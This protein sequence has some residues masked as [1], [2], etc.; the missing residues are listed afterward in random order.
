MRI[1]GNFCLTEINNE[2]IESTR[3]IV[4]VMNTVVAA[5]TS[6]EQRLNRGP[7]SHSQ[8]Q[9]FLP[10]GGGGSLPDCLKTA[11]TTFFSFL[12]L[13]NL[14]KVLQRV[15]NGYFKDNYYFP[16]F[17]RGVQHFLGG[18]GG[19]QGAYADPVGGTGVRT[20]LENHKLY[21]FL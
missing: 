2:S 6:Q 3:I 11:L 5:A 14:F 10:G 19:G 16:R 20:P 9:E 8:I 17:Q 1:R 15:S 21:G 18:G 13:L 4:H 7:V 12:L